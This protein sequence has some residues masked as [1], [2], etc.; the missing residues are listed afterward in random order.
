MR[1]CEKLKVRAREPNEEM[2]LPVKS[3]VRS[4]LSRPS[5]QSG[6]LW[7]LKLC[8]AGLNYGGGQTVA[9][10]GEIGALRFVSTPGSNSAPFVLFDV[11][12]NDGEYLSA[13]LRTV[14]AR[15]RAYSFEPQS[16]SFQKLRARI[17]NDPRVE[18]KKAAVGSEIGSAE[19][20][21]SLE[22]ETTASLR[23][24]AFTGQARSETVMLTTVDRV[25][26]EEHVEHIDMLKI[27]TEGHEMN[28]LRGASRMIELGRIAAIQFEFG[29]TFLHTPFHF[30]DAWEMLSTRY[31]IYRILKHGLFEIPGYSPDLEIYKTANFLCMRKSWNR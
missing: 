17:G 26:E 23:R 7:L 25:C 16:S 12:A 22:G 13:A 21:F 29:D 27:D 19:L 11:G 8:H 30:C 24:D 18:L 14:G 2:E 15:M 20:F 31:R 1:C 5:T 28:V 6:F 10:S 9:N 4:I 3:A